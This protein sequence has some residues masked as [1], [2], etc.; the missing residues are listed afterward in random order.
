MLGDPATS[1]SGHHAGACADVDAA[2]VVAAGP[3][4]VQHCRQPKSACSWLCIAGLVTLCITYKPKVSCAA[5]ASMP[6]VPTPSLPACTGTATCSIALARP[7]TS[8]AVSPCTTVQV[9]L[10]QSRHNHKHWAL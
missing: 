8:S 7:A 1:C 4:D 10:S 2:N 5:G 9:L 3:H 6:Q